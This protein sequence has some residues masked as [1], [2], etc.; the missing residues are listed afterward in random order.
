MLFY[1]DLRL[2]DST[3]PLSLPR[4]A[5]EAAPPPAR[6]GPPAAA[7]GAGESSGVT[8]FKVDKQLG[9][10]TLNRLGAGYQHGDLTFA[11]DA[12]LALGPLALSMQGLSVSGK[13]TDFTPHFNIDGLAIDLS[14][15]PLELSG[16]FLRVAEPAGDSFYGKI[17]VRIAS[18]GLT[19]LGGYRPASAGNDASFFIFASVKIPLGG[20]PFLFVTGFAGGFGINR[21]LVLPT[22]EHLPGT[23]SSRPTRPIRRRRRKIRSRACFPRCRTTFPR[24]I[25]RILD[26]GRNFVHLVRDD[27]SVRAPDG[28]VRRRSRDRAARQLR[29]DVSQ[30]RLLER[31]AYIEIDILASF[32]PSSGRFGVIGVLTPASYLFGG[33][34]HISGG[35]AFYVWYAGP[36]QGQFVVSI[37][38]YHP[39]FKPPPI[40]PAVPRLTIEFALGPL[41]VIGQSYFALTPS[42]MMAG[43]SISATW[44]SGPLKVWFNAGIDFL[45]EWAPFHYDA[46]AYMMLGCALDLGLFTITVHIGCDIHIWGPEFGGQVLVDLDIIS[47][48]I[49]FGALPA[50]PPPIG[51]PAFREGFLPSASASPVKKAPPRQANA[52]RP[53]AARFFVEPHAAG[54]AAAAAPTGK[55]KVVTGAVELGMKA[56]TAPG[57]DW[58]LE[59]EGFA[60][61]AVSTLPA[62]HVAWGRASGTASELSTKLSDYNGQTT[63]TRSP[64]TLML[65]DATKV[66]DEAAGVVWNP[67]LGL[68]PM[69]LT[70]ISSTLDVLVERHLIENPEGVY[71]ERVTDLA[72]QPILLDVAAALY[73][74]SPATKDPN[75]TALVPRALVGLRIVP[76]RRTPRTVSDVLVSDLLFQSGYSTGFHLADGATDG[77]FGVTLSA[78]KP[79]VL[80]IAVTGPGAPSTAIP[81]TSYVMAALAN[82]FFVAQRS[83]ALAALEALGTAG[84]RTRAATAIDVSLMSTQDRA[85][86]LARGRRARR[87]ATRTTH[88]A[89]GEAQ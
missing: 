78:P 76:V 69:G 33:L 39:A 55:E 14:R 17:S 1:A 54:L 10:L 7:P 74:N 38:G 37:G 73:A 72:V 64:D 44:V 35:F 79:D 48:T 6:G 25:G 43:L 75:E 67:K 4:S 50:P 18:F 85:D 20:P 27:R 41:K 57:F 63:A 59:P 71:S 23:C 19:A 83:A 29:D 12:G 62:N 77:R 8:Y 22:F 53:S 42:A 61:T 32:S 86:R 58:V 70:D 60:I 49:A 15:G 21:K 36:N 9:P 28:V 3:Q 87:G 13:L 56:Q 80:D 82:Q 16:A 11:V 81:N 2:G 31:V 40:Y 24:G 66:F 52:F 89:G 46:E 84:F 65:A 34:V 5:P 45:I 51:W 47:F 68:R 30:G 88:H 26:R